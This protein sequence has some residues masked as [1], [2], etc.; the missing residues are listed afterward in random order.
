MKQKNYEHNEKRTEKCS[1]KN[2]IQH[3]RKYVSS[4]ILGEING[5]ER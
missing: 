3:N 5:V 1:E 4:S 2:V